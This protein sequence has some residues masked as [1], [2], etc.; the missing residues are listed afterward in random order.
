M[1]PFALL[2]AVLLA[3][4]ALAQ[5]PNIEG[6][7]QDT[8]RRLLYAPDA[9]PGYKFGQWTA[10][11]QEQTY[12]AAKQI[13]RAASAYELLDLLYDDE[14]QIKVARATSEAIDFTRTNRLSGCST[15]HACTLAAADQLFCALET[16]CPAAGAEQVV[17]RGEERYARRASCERDGKRQQQGIPVKCR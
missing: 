1:K 14:E 4:L 12:P 17:W 9:P 6:Y 10:L 15:A 5:S 13:R 16:R 11:D 2:L 8:E 3:G 7:W